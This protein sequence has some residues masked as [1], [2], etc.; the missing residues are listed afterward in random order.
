MIHHAL[1][2][3]AATPRDASALRRIAA[4]ERRPPL[5]GHALI[6]YRD[7]VTVAAVALTSGSVF[8][9]RRHATGDAVRL[10]RLRRYQLLRQGGDVGP[11]R[12][13]LRRLAPAS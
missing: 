5:R 2:I 1:T 3:R 4:R 12:S 13:L 11:A 9:D 7:G 8:A 6:A 10:L